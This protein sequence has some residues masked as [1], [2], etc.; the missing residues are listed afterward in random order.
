MKVEDINW[1]PPEW[2]F[3][4]F[5]LDGPDRE[6]IDLDEVI[7]VL[8]LLADT[9]TIYDTTALGPA[10]H[11]CHMLSTRQ[12]IDGEWHRWLNAKTGQPI[13]DERTFEPLTLFRRLTEALDTTEFDYVYV[14][15]R[16]YHMR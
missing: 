16:K 5:P 3:T 14:R 9:T 7:K 13:N 15:A 10:M 12:G 11:V 4:C 6:T 1:S 8:H 2:A